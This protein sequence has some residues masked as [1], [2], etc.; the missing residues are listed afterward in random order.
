MKIVFSIISIFLLLFSVSIA[1]KIKTYRAKEIKVINNSSKMFRVKNYF[2]TRISSDIGSE[3]IPEVF[4]IGDI[5]NVDGNILN[6]KYIEVNEIL[7]D[8]IY[9]NEILGRKGDIQCIAVESLDDIPS[10]E[11]DQKEFWLERKWINIKHCE[12]IK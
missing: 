5:I 2:V 6:V 3:G 1:S 12:V 7:E 8:M 10:P 4:K 11:N 9:K